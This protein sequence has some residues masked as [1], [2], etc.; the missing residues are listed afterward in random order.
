MRE[1]DVQ[2]ALENGADAVGFIVQSPISP[3]NLTLERAERLMKSVPI[4]TLKVA[5][6][7]TE[8][9]R[10]I[11][12]ICSKLQPDALQ[13]YGKDLQLIRRIRRSHPET[14]L[15]LATGIRDKSSIDSAT[16]SA[17]ESDAVLADT[18]NKQGM[19]G[20]GQVH[21]WNLTATV[22]KR[23]HPKPLILAGGLTPM[24]VRQA[25]RQVEPYGVDVSSGVERAI[26]VKDHKKI[27]EFIANAKGAQN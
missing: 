17:K 7:I 15:I 11:K 18:L 2:V 13:L 12:K 21:D 23:I 5:V 3:R 20:T 22:R 14:R 19:G 10:D 25:I 9:I 6:T 1:E 27:R 16:R 4:F 26:G 24:N 8:D